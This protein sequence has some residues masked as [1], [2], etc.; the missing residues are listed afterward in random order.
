MLLLKHLPLIPALAVV[1]VLVE[2]VV[3]GAL[4]LDHQKVRLMSLECSERH[5]PDLVVH[6]VL[7]I[8]QVKRL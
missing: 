1:H 6:E 2:E 4:Q 5:V 3:A 7:A 8:D